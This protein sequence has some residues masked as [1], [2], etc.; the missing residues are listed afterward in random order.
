MD[1]LHLLVTPLVS[2][3]LLTIALLGIL[4]EMQ[5]L[6]GIA[7]ALAVAAL[8]LFFGSHIAA[9]LTGPFVI[10]LAALGVIG[11][12]WELHVVPGHGIPGLVGAL[13]LLL[14]MVLAFG[15]L[16]AA[17]FFVALQT[18]A[19]AIVVTVVLFAL[20][21]RALPQNAWIAKLTFAGVQGADY[22]TSTDRTA[23]RGRTGVAY[24]L[25]RPAGVALIDGEHVDVLT[26]GPFLPAGTPIRVT[27]VEGARIFVERAAPESK[28]LRS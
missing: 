9:G 11:I 10:L 23:L 1:L 28:E 12:L 25:L 8:I 2:G 14:S 4:L 24:S 20:A 19:S 16:G 6:H 13:L 5:T 22:V 21:V 26:G 3:L 27:R 7:G 17:A 15:P 18:V